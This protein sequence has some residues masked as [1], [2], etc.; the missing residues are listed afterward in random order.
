MPAKPR[1]KRANALL[2][3]SYYE[4]PGRY[5]KLQDDGKYLVYS[6]KE[7][8]LL[9]KLDGIATEKIN[10]K[11]EVTEFEA[12][13][14]E[15]QTLRRIDFAGLIGGRTA[16]ALEGEGSKRI[17]CTESINLVQ[18]KD[19]GIEHAKLY[20]FAAWRFPIC[21]NILGQAF[22]GKDP[23]TGETHDQVDRI[24]TWLKDAIERPHYQLVRNGL[25]SF[26]VGPPGSG[27]SLWLDIVDELLGRR[28]TSPHKYGSG[29][30]NFNGEHAEANLLAADDESHHT[31]FKNRTRFGA[32]VKQVVAVSGRR[33]RGLHKEAITLYLIQSLIVVCNPGPAMQV[34]P[35]LTDDL[36]DKVLALY[37]HPVDFESLGFDLP[38]EREKFRKA[39]SDEL[40]YLVHYLLNVWQPSKEMTGR[41]GCAAW[42][43]PSILR[44]LRSFEFSSR[45]EEFISRFL[46]TSPRIE[47]KDL[48]KISAKDAAIIEP[49]IKEAGGSLVGW[50]GTT[51]E[52]RNR[53]LEDSDREGFLR[54]HER[55]EILKRAVSYFGR[56][57]SALSKDNP[58]L[59]WRSRSRKGGGNNWILLCQE[60]DR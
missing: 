57:L 17:L 40:P 44:E 18:P 48:E 50:I 33:I 54:H 22:K 59:F 45:L 56:D 29:E 58:K 8:K 11:Q 60:V 34:L 35:P 4:Y 37:F 2:E 26:L 36:I 51:D 16:G 41:F 31:D 23:E 32:F 7:Y 42:A 1:R 21:G 3:R 39:I 25:A 47:A 46:E 14:A 49:A 6:E 15:L 28:K 24:L 52:L 9:A 13:C 20:D 38:H 27:K 10:P 43:H 19:P 55:G 5:W 30:D 12:L 53:L